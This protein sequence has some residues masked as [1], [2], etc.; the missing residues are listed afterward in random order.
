VS[1]FLK[2]CFSNPTGYSRQTFGW[3][4]LILL[5][6]KNRQCNICFGFICISVTVTVDQSNILCFACFKTRTASD[7]RPKQHLHV[8]G[9]TFEEQLTSLVRDVLVPVGFEVERFTKLPYL[10]EGD[11]Y[12]SYYVLYDAVFV[13]R[14]VSD[15]CL[16]SDGMFVNCWTSTGHSNG[17]VHRVATC[18]EKSGIWNWSWKSPGNG[19][20]CFGAC[21]VLTS[22]LLSVLERP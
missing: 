1:L 8:S 12:H 3:L 5:S 7:H 4:G 19:G 22:G 16:F 2:S 17:T 6:N 10:S 15:Q 14:S 13:L 21:G 18:L 9:E 20:K 11:I